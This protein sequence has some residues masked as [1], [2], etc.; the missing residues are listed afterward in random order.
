MQK[1]EIKVWFQLDDKSAG[2]QWSTAVVV[3]NQIYLF[4]F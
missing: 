3:I 2:T 4:F 1:A